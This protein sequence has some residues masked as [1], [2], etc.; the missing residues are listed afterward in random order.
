MKQ[1]VLTLPGGEQVLVPDWAFDD[2][3]PE[4]EVSWRSNSA[5][6]SRWLPLSIAGGDVRLESW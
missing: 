5:T 6:S 3:T 1:L 2:D 4:H